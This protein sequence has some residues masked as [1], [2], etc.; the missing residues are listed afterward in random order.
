MNGRSP[1]PSERTRGNRSTVQMAILAL[2]VA[3]ISLFAWHPWGTRI[4][5][6][7]STQTTT[8]SA[9]RPAIQ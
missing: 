4:A 2:I 6:S 1:F 3:V 7:A 5:A 8:N 9:S